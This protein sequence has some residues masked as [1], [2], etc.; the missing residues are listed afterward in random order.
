VLVIANKNKHDDALRCAEMTFNG[1]VA[2]YKQTDDIAYIESALELF[3]NEVAH[4]AH[5]VYEE[6]KRKGLPSYMAADLVEH[7]FSGLKE[8]V[9]KEVKSAKKSVADDILKEA[10]HLMNGKNRELV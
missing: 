9:K 6:Q 7:A 2:Q 8:Y 4:A 5:K 3:R 1:L 10:R